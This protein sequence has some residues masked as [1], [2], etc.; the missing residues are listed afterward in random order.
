MKERFAI[1]G[2]LSI[3]AVLL[4]QSVPFF[5][6]GE[7]LL[8]PTRL[9][10]RSLLPLLKEGFVKGCAHITGGGVEENAVRMLDP[11]ASLALKVDATSWKKPAI[12]DWLAAM[13]PV[14]ASTMMRTFNCGI[15]FVLVVAASD[16]SAVEQRLIDASETPVRI[17]SVVKKQGD[18]LISFTNMEAAFSPSRFAPGPKSTIKVGI[19]ISGT[20]SN[21]EKL[22]ESSRKPGSYCEVVVVI[23]NKEGVKG[24]EIANAMGVE[25]IV[26]P[27]T[28]V[29]E[30][31]D[32]KITE[33]EFKRFKHSISQVVLK[34]VHIVKDIKFIAGAHAVRDA[35]KFG[36]KVTGCTIHY[37]DEQ[38]D[39]G[40][41]I[42]QGAVPIEDEDDEASLHAKIRIIEHKLYPEAMQRVAKIAICS[43]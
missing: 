18:S 7:V 14:T 43:G 30:E 35:L 4:P 13:G 21:M 41:I 31:G 32:S 10:V 33:A 40:S 19:L 5:C 23:S 3:L 39:H 16:V 26:I 25:T 28:Q 20:G 34:T 2:K 37:V 22:I 11:T 12:F 1:K 8:T 36:A 6:F 27:H 17:G 42:A 9:Y 15:G 29:R 24:L 38:V